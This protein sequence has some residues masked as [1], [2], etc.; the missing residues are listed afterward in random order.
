[1]SMAISRTKYTGDARMGYMGDPG[2]FGDIFRGIKGGI[3]GLIGGGPLGVLGGAVR[4]FTGG[5]QPPVPT[6]GPG[7]FP[8]MTARQVSTR[9]RALA[10][11]RPV[12]DF[13]FGQQVQ[14]P[15]VVAAVQRFLPG[16]ETGMMMAPMN[17]R[18][19]GYHLNKS[20]YFL[21]S[22]EFVPAGTRWV[23]DRKRNPANARATSRSIARI[24]GAKKYQ[25]S[26]SSISIRKKC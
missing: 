11:G 22:G 5:K 16:G 14:R 4:G 3:G 7:Q 8:L 9:T 20:S 19:G 25:S 21:L 1:M 13:G 17:G 12:H 10:A 18:A 23:K 2:L 24:K 26:L 6:A 15:G